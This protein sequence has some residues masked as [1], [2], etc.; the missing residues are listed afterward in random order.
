MPYLRKK[1]GYIMFYVLMIGFII[2]IFLTL[3]YSIFGISISNLM[4]NLGQSNLDL[5][6]KNILNYTYNL[7]LNDSLDSEILAERDYFDK[8]ISSYKKDFTQILDQVD[9]KNLVYVFHPYQEEQSFINLKTNELYDNNINEIESFKIY[10]NIKEKLEGT[11]SLEIQAEHKKYNPIEREEE[12]ELKITMIRKKA[13]T[14]VQKCFYTDNPDIGDKTAVGDFSDLFVNSLDLSENLFKRHSDCTND[15]AED[16]LKN[17]P[18]EEDRF[19]GDSLFNIDGT[20]DLKNNTYILII[21]PKSDKITHIRVNAIGNNSY[22][23]TVNLYQKL[24]PKSSGIKEYQQTKF[25]IPYY[26]EDLGILSYPY[27][28]QGEDLGV[29][30]INKLNFQL[31]IKDLTLNCLGNC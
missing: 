7:Y 12:S 21:E 26:L 29:E 11:E 30:D 8:Q 17:P 5:K 1:S 10:W 31:I 25:I 19:Y 9:N 20:L 27:T 22:I 14:Y 16:L 2:I 6:A 4:T 13:G 3:L 18:L 28:Y 24:I 15:L 23:P